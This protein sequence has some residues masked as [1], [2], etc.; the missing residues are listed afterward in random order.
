M[1]MLMRM[2]R[3]YI[4]I[5]LDYPVAAAEAFAG[6]SDS[7]NFVY[8]SGEGVCSLCPISQTLPTNKNPRQHKPP[9]A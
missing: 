7:F 2:N 6:L 8:V 3:E 5:T 1:G 4:K 9:P